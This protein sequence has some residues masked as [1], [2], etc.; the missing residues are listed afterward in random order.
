MGDS[1]PRANGPMAYERPAG[2]RQAAGLWAS[3]VAVMNKN[4][5]RNGA[6]T[7]IALSLG[8]LALGQGPNR[9]DAQVSHAGSGQ[10]ARSPEG[11]GLISAADQRKQILREMQQMRRQ[12]EQMNATLKGGLNVKVT[13][14]PEIRLPKDDG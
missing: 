8:I 7:V 10:Q 1:T 2:D 5:Y 6:L 12:I 13:D 11:G 4:G 14:M 3:G 9:A